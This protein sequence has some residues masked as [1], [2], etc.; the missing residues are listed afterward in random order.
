M[1]ESSINLRF[2]GMA[3]RDPRS[4]IGRSQ[5]A[6]KPNEK[7]IKFIGGNELRYNSGELQR[8]RTSQPAR[9][10]KMEA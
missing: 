6:G 4:E 5:R 1:V 2:S 8:P 7:F 9:P 10:A 3:I